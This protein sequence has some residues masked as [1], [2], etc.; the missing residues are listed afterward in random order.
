M[1][2]GNIHTYLF[3]YKYKIPPRDKNEVVPGMCE[4]T[5]IIIIKKESKKGR[6]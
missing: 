1:V 2:D 4:N 5:M 6:M 3:Y